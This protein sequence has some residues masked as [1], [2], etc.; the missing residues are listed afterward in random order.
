MSRI[1]AVCSK[2][3][4]VGNLVS[5]A[6]NR[7]KRWIYPNVHKMNYILTESGSRSVCRGAV[8]TKC[9]KAGKVEKVI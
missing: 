4:Q 2:R 1:C 6:R 7:V 5:H 8:C 3:P 9:V